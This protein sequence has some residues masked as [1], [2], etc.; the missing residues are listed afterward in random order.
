MRRVCDSNHRFSR[1][2]DGVGKDPVPQ[3]LRSINVQH[4]SD[5]TVGMHVYFP[6]LELLGALHLIQCTTYEIFA[7]T[8]GVTSRTNSKRGMDALT[9]NLV[10]LGSLGGPEECKI[11]RKKCT[12]TEALLTTAI[13]ST[14]SKYYEQQHPS[15]LFP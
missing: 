3:K 9:H 12:N 10:H 1:S 6:R 4:R 14:F 13:T 5:A 8:P 11:L 2:V 15:P 7:N